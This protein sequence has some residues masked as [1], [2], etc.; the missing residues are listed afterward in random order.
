MDINHSKSILDQ[1]DEYLH[2]NEPQ[3]HSTYTENDKE[4]INNDS[5]YPNNWLADDIQLDLDHI[6][7]SFFNNNR[8]NNA[9]N[10]VNSHD[11]NGFNNFN[12]NKSNGRS[13]PYNTNSN[14]NS[15]SHF[16]GIQSD[17]LFSPSESPMVAPSQASLGLQITPFMNPQIL[18]SSHSNSVSDINTPFMHDSNPTDTT[19]NKGNLNTSSTTTSHLGYYSPL[20][21]PAINQTQNQNQ[22]YSSS[23]FTLPD[24]VVPLSDGMTN[25]NSKNIKG[26]RSSSISKTKRLSFSSSNANTNKSSLTNS[27]SKVQKNSPYLSGNRSRR[28]YQE[29]K[30]KANS[31]NTSVGTAPNPNKSTTSSSASWDDMVFKLPESNSNNS[32][33]TA[34][35]PDDIPD[36]STLTA[37]QFIVASNVLPISYANSM[38]SFQ[39]SNEKTESW[40]MK[41]QSA[42][43]NSS[44]SL[45][46]NGTSPT[47]S[48]NGIIP[49]DSPAMK[50]RKPTNPDIINDMNNLTRSKSRSSESKPPK[51][52]DTKKEVHKVA[53][54][55][56]RNRLNNALHEL[57]ALIPEELRATIS[58]PSKATTAELACV[59][60]RQ[61]LRD[62]RELQEAQNQNN[63]QSYGT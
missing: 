28:Q 54:Q 18:M 6:S 12:N 22:I 29:L 9:T 42:N 26:K 35:N 5:L 41:T 52:D 11:N 40:K 23:N 53:E 61:L 51:K 17:L 38:T 58:I 3:L 16:T 32:N 14:K 30:N 7:E 10:P 44:T 19:N 45:H 34:S 60:I 2:E 57:S 13:K 47:N 15:N 39:T 25:T 8:N 24:S 43:T 27:S 33:S 46:S 31:T 63:H 49:V 37:S 62:K 21:S 59:Y 4:M 56:R 55:E 1:V 20:S 48:K 50:A 36:G